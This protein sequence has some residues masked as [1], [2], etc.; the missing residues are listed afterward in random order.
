MPE[1]GLFPLGI[2]LL[3]TE[4]IPL[5]IFEP[6]YRELIAECLAETREFGLI[7]ADD[8]GLREIGTRAA[9]V[10]VV[11]RF[12]DGKLNIV[13]E[14]RE[15]FR[16]V[17]LT[18]GRSFRT[19]EVEA[20]RD[21]TPEADRAKLER[22]ATLMRRVAE[23]AGADADQAAETAS[24]APSFELAARVDFDPR[25]K[26]EL[27]ELRSEPNRLELLAK[28]LERA[29]AALEQQQAVSEAAS[30]NGRVYPRDPR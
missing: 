3:P 26:Q 18:S 29:A 15:R 4:R 21:E 13:V 28:V 23:L 27:L 30:R 9:V 5:H 11:E 10:E 25:L 24:P 14:G 1:L 7:L 22:A 6:R 2:V 12:A 17:G 16:V 8:E 20:V 19:A